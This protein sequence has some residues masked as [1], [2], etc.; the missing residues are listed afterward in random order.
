MA[1]QPD[2]EMVAEQQHEGKP[3]ET[4]EEKEEQGFTPFGTDGERIDGPWEVIVPG[5]AHIRATPSHGAASLGVLPA[6]NILRGVLG[7]GG[8]LCW[9]SCEGGFV[10]SQAATGE[11]MQIRPVE[12]ADSSSRNG[13]EAQQ[14]TRA[15]VASRRTKGGGWSQASRRS[16]QG[17][18]S[19]SWSSDRWR[20]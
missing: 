11:E 17:W 20:R 18:T 9:I 8:G 12:V 3:L 19:S 15:R 10:A 16:S 4:K 13:E 14:A 6:G 1:A 2:V 7:L 5:G